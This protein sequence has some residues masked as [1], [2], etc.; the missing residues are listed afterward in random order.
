M[1]A[2]RA[3]AA[4]FALTAGLGPEPIT[5]TGRGMRMIGVGSDALARIC[6]IMLRSSSNVAVILIR[7]SVTVT[8]LPTGSS[9]EDRAEDFGPGWTSMAS[10]VPMR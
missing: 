7:G 10:V 2:A 1:L 3:P 8:F 6:R 9:T 5:L 4:P